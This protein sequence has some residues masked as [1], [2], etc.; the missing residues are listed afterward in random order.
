MTCGVWRSRWRGRLPDEAVNVVVGLSGGCPFMTSA[1]LRGMV[2]SGVLV[3][4]PEGWRVEP[5]ALADLHSSNWAAGVLSR[6]IELLPQATIDLLVV[7]AVLGKEFDL[8]LAAEIARQPACETAAL[9]NKARERHFV[10]LQADGVRCAFI[11]DKIRSALLA[12][13]SAEA[14]C[15]LHRQIALSLQKN[16][17][18]RVFDLAYHFDAAGHHDRALPNTLCWPPGKLGR[19]IRSKW[20][21]SNIALPSAARSRP[22]GPCST[23]SPKDWATC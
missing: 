13:L 1:M 4:E 19:S 17:P 22:I 16:F 15:D 10:W 21:S 23:A 14:R 3:A 7:G 18:D 9:L 2:E 6:R 11:H 12:R 5:L 8:P 20:P